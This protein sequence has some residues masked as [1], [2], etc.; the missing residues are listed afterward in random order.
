MAYF[1]MVHHKPQQFE[2][3]MQAIANPNDLFFIHVD[4]KSR[5]GIKAD[6]R[7]VMADVRRILK[8][9]PNVVMLP[10]R[11]TNW[12]GW[13]LS[14]ILLDTIRLALESDVEWTHFINLSGQCYPI[15][16]I[17]DIRDRLARSYGAIHIEML[18]IAELP[19]D[20]WHHRS[21]RMFE[22]PLKAHILKGSQPDPLSFEM[23]H[24]GSQWV[25]LPRD[26]CRWIVEAPITSNISHY[27]KR[28]LL[29]DELIMQTLVANSPFL[30]RLAPFYGRAIQWPGPKV[31]TTAD[32]KWL[33]ESDSLFARKF[34]CVQDVTILKNLAD[35][36][37]ASY[38]SS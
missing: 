20:D 11:F 12:G 32:S 19:D 31:L 7:G 35:R 10:S 37:G 6:R 5:L 24:K 23:R 25:M 8:H 29:S 27:L 14:Q 13:S 34:D 18:P 9:A 28:R 36:I 4:L 1:V 21:I 38:P 17:D 33:E 3:L 30:D 16:P 26:F 22:T 2:W 15:K